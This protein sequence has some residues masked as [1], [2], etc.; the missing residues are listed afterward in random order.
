MNNP[1]RREQDQKGWLARNVTIGDIIAIV[2][3]AVMVVVSFAHLQAGVQA[4]EQKAAVIEQKIKE[5]ADAVDNRLD[6][7][8]KRTQESLAEIKQLLIR[9][10]DK[11]EKVRTK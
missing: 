4:A 10:D 7:S 3:A 9:L 8:E 5:R 2:S 6:R 1:S 11:V